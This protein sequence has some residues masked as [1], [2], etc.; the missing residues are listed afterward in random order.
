MS[1]TRLIFWVMGCLLSGWLSVGIAGGDHGHHHAASITTSSTQ[2][3]SNFELSGEQ[4]ELV[5][6]LNE[7]RRQ[8]TMYLDRQADNEPVHLAEVNLTINQENYTFSLEQGRATISLKESLSEGVHSVQAKIAYRFLDQASREEFIAGEWMVH[9]AHHEHTSWRSKIKSIIKRLL[10]LLIPICLVGVWLLWKRR[11]KIVSF[12]RVQLLLFAVLLFAYLGSFSTQVL[13]HGDEQPSAAPSANTPQRLPTGEIVIPKSTQHEI[14]LRTQVMRVEQVQKT[15]LLNGRVVMDPNAGGRVQATLGGRLLA[16]PRGFPS[17]G[18]QVVAGQ[19]LGYVVPSAGQLERA[20]QQAQLA[21]LEAN[22]RLVQKRLSRL[23]ELADTV[24]RSQIEGLESDLDSL[25]GRIRALRMGLQQ[26][27]A[28]VAP[29][30]GVIASAH[31]VAGQVIE[32]SQ[33]LFE[34]VQVARLRIEAITYDFAI[35]NQIKSATLSLETQDIPMRLL[36]KGKQLIGQALPL[37]FAPEQL[38]TAFTELALGQL[39]QVHAQLADSLTGIVI[40]QQALV[41]NPANQ[42][43]VWVKVGPQRYRPQIVQTVPLSR[44][45]MLVTNGL[46]VGDRVAVAGV[47]LLNQV[48]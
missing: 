16:G 38:P 31:A 18:Q 3:Q 7:D 47:S 2:F 26:R 4:L 35:A 40:A 21:E 22:E 32:P 19:V 29:V 25:A 36:G 5:G 37:L 43:I 45:Q 28:L 42:T 48:R 11:K 33:I 9:D 1:F 44:H 41:K 46:K 23:R 30:S 13:A 14:G 6:L 10:W 39:V 20:S 12:P 27:D 8:L 34:I 15:L 17:L 24:P